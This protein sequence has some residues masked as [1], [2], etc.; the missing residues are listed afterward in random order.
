M[1]WLDKSDPTTFQF[2]TSSTRRS[3]AAMVNLMARRTREE[4]GVFVLAGAANMYN[5]Y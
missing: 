4:I 1:C 5:R 3:V 2:S